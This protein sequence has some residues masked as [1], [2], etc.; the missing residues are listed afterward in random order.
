MSSARLAA[1]KVSR[2]KAAA[3]RASAAASRGV[4]KRTVQPLPST[5]A[6][7]PLAGAISIY[8][9]AAKGS[10]HDEHVARGRARERRKLLIEIDLSHC[11]RRAVVGRQD[12][13]C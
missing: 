3:A 8:S 7:P 11:S 9:Q 12:G 4:A 5:R 1:P 13:E 10:R 2:K 6:S